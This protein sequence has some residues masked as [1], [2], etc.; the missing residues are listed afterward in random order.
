MNRAAGRDPL[1]Q[2]QFARAVRAQ[3]ASRATSQTRRC[4]RAIEMGEEALWMRAKRPPWPSKGYRDTMTYVLQLAEEPRFPF[5][6][7]LIKSL[8]FMMTN[9]DRTAPGRWRAAPSTSR[10]EENQRIV[11]EGRRHGLRRWPRA[12][13]RHLPGSDGDIPH[14]RQNRDGSP[15]PRQSIPSETETVAW[16]F[17]LKAWCSPGRNPGLLQHR[18]ITSARNARSVHDVLA[19]VGASSWQPTRD[20]AL[21]SL[22]AHRSSSPSENRS[23]PDQRDRDRVPRTRTTR[24][25]LPVPERTLKPSSTPPPGSES[26]GPS[27]ARSSKTKAMIRSVNR[28]QP[29]T[30]RSLTNHW[31]PHRSRRTPRTLLHGRP[32]VAAIRERVIKTATHATTSDPF[33]VSGLGYRIKKSCSDSRLSQLQLSFH[34][35]T[36][37]SLNQTNNMPE[38]IRSIGKA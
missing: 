16:H 15:Q 20:T 5:R 35:Q 7:T 10:R 33:A 37:P 9:Y 23:A 11:Y 6:R 29:A 19:E 22:R 34:R 36:P 28:P 1:R 17:C 32:R 38:T 4:A 13:T 2:V 25:P 14:R 12:P 27:T 30:C 26:G 21:D 31:A 24:S 18:G 8:H 3:T